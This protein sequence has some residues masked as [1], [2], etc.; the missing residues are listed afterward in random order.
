MEVNGLR[1]PAALAQIVHKGQGVWTTWIMKEPVDA[2]G[3]HFDRDRL[4]ILGYDPMVEETAALPDRF[5][6]VSEED[7]RGEA[8]NLGFIPY[9]QGYS[10]CSKIV[11]FGQDGSGWPFCLDYREN[12]QEPRV[13][14]RDET[15][16]RR[17]AQNFAAFMELIEPYDDDEFDRR[18]DLYG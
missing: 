7:A 18:M 13:V 5:V 12:L 6:Y 14:F 16:W 11:V 3:D 15:H 1:L 8:D 9:I 2:Y 4:E 10:D 17:L